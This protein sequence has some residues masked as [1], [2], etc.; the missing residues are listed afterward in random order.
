MT[1]LS[2]FLFHG[3]NHV[4]AVP[5]GLGQQGVHHDVSWPMPED[6]LGSH[7]GSVEWRHQHQFDLVKGLVGPQFLAL[8]Q[9]FRAELGID[10]T[11]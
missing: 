9:S 6:D 3:V 5:E 1:K 4:R 11:L 8:H 7:E 10:V 2:H